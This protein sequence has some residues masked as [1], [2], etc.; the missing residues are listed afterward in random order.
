MPDA[1]PEPFAVASGEG[2]LVMTQMTRGGVVLSG[3]LA[4]KLAEV[5]CEAH[6]GSEEVER[7]KPFN[8]ADKGTYWRVEGS[9]NRDGKIDGPGAF[10]VSLGKYDGRVT[11]FGRWLPYHAH[12]TAVPL[13]KQHLAGKKTRDTE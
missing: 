11:D 13:I 5:L 4:V 12:P 10:F 6:Y 3:D 7:Q 2:M 8:V 1:P 9:L